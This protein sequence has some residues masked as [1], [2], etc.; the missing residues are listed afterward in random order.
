MKL[1]TAILSVFFLTGFANAKPEE[2][3]F[4]AAGMVSLEVFP[5]RPNYDSIKGGDEPE[6][7]WIL[8]VTDND[9]KE[10]YQLVIVDN[11]TQKYTTL[12]RCIGKIIE[13]KGVVWEG[14]TG[15]HHTPFLI[16][17]H[18]IQEEPD[19]PHPPRP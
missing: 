1:L 6:K 3:P 19:Q 13:V 10:R 15:H 14:H 5:G 12:N 11:P 7:A 9:K 4:H 2:A 18:S 16:T 17:V 8:T